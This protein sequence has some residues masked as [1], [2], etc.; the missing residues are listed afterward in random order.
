MQWLQLPSA[1]SA[2]PTPAEC[3]SDRTDHV[4]LSLQ[5]AQCA[6][7]SWALPAAG[8][9]L[10]PDG[11]CAACWQAQSCSLSLLEADS[12]QE[13]AVTLSP[14]AGKSANGKAGPA[15]PADVLTLGAWNADSST[16]AVATAGGGIYLVSRRWE[17]LSCGPA[18]RHQLGYIE[19]P[20]LLPSGQ[21]QLCTAFAPADDQS[22]ERCALQ[23]R[24]G[25]SRLAIQ[26]EQV[27]P[28]WLDGAGIHGPRGPPGAEWHRRRVDASP[29]ARRPQPATE[30]SAEREGGCRL[31][32]TAL[33]TLQRQ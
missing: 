5:L 3:R 9:C 28:G 7:T 29:G 11:Q 22:P 2:I 33:R 13:A 31:P 12:K 32:S 17:L 1:S 24:S 21:A 15:K 25:A 6:G 20:V 30:A 27:G 26:A 4:K 19:C 18:R 23:G 8:A 14:A 16:L 10:S